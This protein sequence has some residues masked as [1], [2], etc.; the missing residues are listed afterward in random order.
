MLEE[1]VGD[2]GLAQE[3]G[4]HEGALPTADP[5]SDDSLTANWNTGWV[6]R[7][8]NS[9]SPFTR[10]VRVAWKRQVVNIN[11]YVRVLN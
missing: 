11:L 8:T 6:K 2:L 3:V 10:T 1:G 9:F 4:G 5:A 7:G